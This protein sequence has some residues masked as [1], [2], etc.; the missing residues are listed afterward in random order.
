MQAAV[1]TIEA[2]SDPKKDFDYGKQCYTMCDYERNRLK[3]LNSIFDLHFPSTVPDSGEHRLSS[4]GGRN[5][6]FKSHFRARNSPGLPKRIR[7]R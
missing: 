4:I 6:H 3:V 2:G 5:R 1:L 7:T